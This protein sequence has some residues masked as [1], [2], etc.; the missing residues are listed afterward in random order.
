MEQTRLK[1]ITLKAMEELEVFIDRAEPERKNEFVVGVIVSETV[2]KDLKTG[3]VKEGLELEMYISANDKS[4][5]P[6]LDSTY[7]RFAKDQSQEEILNTIASALPTQE[8]IDKM[9]A[10][11]EAQRRMQEQFAAMQSGMAQPE[12]KPDNMK[13]LTPSEDDE[14]VDQNGNTGISK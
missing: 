6:K 10:Q 9:K 4:N 8:D 3:G 2:F 1:E 13:E 11:A 14:L 7:V 12:P 5:S